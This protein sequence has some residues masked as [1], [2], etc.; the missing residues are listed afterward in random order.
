M[1]FL[2]WLR[3]RMRV[4]ETEK[5][6]TCNAIHYEKEKEKNKFGSVENLKIDLNLYVR[7]ICSYSFSGKRGG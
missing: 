4:Y 6:S 7:N 2:G 5:K 1:S 3:V